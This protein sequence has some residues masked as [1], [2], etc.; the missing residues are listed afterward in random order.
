MRASFAIGGWLR[1]RWS[2]KK[3]RPIGSV[4][5]RYSVRTDIGNDISNENPSFDEGDAG[6]G[7]LELWTAW[8]CGMAAFVPRPIGSS[9][10]AGASQT[11]RA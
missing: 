8:S 10:S 3:V 5:P 11:R 1:G 4:R 2:P 7:G 9:S 6:A